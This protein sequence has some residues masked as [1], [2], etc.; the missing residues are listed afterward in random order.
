LAE[1]GRPPQ[2]AGPLIR[3]H[4]GRENPDDLLADLTRG[5]AAYRSAKTG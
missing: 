2:M 3:L 4:I 5:L 1:R